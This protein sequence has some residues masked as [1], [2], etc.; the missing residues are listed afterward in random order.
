MILPNKQWVA[1]NEKKV[2]VNIK[3]INDNSY[4]YLACHIAKL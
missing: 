2:N 3:E 4:V 1:I